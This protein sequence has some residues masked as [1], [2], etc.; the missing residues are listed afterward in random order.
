MSA[1]DTKDSQDPN[2]DPNRRAAV[3]RARAED[4]PAAAAVFA[5]TFDASV[6]AR[7]GAHSSEAYLR[8]WVSDPREFMVV[9]EDPELGIV[10]GLLGTMRKDD[11]R[12]P[13][14]RAAAPSFGPAFAH[15]LLARPT[16]AVEFGRRLVSGARDALA[17][18]VSP[19]PE[20]EVQVF[21]PQWP[22]AS[23]IGEHL[24]YVAAY[25][26]APEA[27]GQRLATRMCARAQEL[28]AE[29]GL[30]WC[31]VATYTDNI[32]SQTTAL[33]AGF[34][35]VKQVG[36][37][38]Q[39]R[40]FIGQGEPGDL[41]VELQ[42]SPLDDPDLPDRWRD[43]LERTPDG[44]GFHTWPWRRALLTDCPHAL[45]AT[46]FLGDVPVALF[47]L[48]FDPQAG[49]LGWWG[50]HRSNYSGP[51]YD[52]EHLPSVLAGLRSIAQELQPRAIDF[53]GLREHSPF[54]RAALDLVLGEHGR[55]HA[56]RMIA[57]SE[58]D[59][60]EGWDGV[61]RRRKRKHR[62]NW[63]RALRKLEELGRVEF[64]EHTSS[65]AIAAV[66]DDAIR[67]YE[68]R[69]AG[70]NVEQA[71]G[72]EREAFQRATASAL[73]DE[74]HAV[75]SVLSVQDEVIAFSYALRQGGVSNS[76]TLAHDDDYAPYSPGQLLLNDVLER[77]ARR[78]DPSFDFSVGDEVYKEVWST[79]RIGV[80][81][82]AWGAGAAARCAKDRLLAAAREQPTLRRLKQEGLRSLVPPAPPPLSDWA[83]HR[84]AA[85]DTGLRT[86]PLDL[87]GLRTHVPPELFA[88][89]IDRVF[90][91]DTTVLVARDDSPVAIVW[92][93]AEFRRDGLCRGPADTEVFFDLRLLEPVDPAAVASAL[94]SCLLVAAPIEG[95]EVERTFMAEVDL[96]P[97]R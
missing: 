92:K 12:T 33:R 2:Q 79:A 62:N 56:A 27:R 45:V 10:G 1:P 21:E 68:R 74:G 7:M 34:R 18:R 59:L 51:L 42:R 55:P 26:V 49:V 19:P 54:R 47:P 94:G 22:E 52:P 84:V 50:T 72:R 90:R 14:L 69:W 28:F 13:V 11:H 93:A 53:S 70:F 25:W 9:A 87:Q 4:L 71:F 60:R 20:P 5:R 82:L 58:I 65:G 76:Y 95:L 39:Y 8:A 3:R 81:R 15:D 30:L 38:L 43:L 6:W 83:V 64:E 73:A 96:T 48:D 85:A 35:L 86:E 80:Y 57:A 24:G 46:V 97:K 31:E 63:R 67:L 29:Q 44:S 32:A 66:M 37:H 88:L 41:R 36:E 91:G 23:E 77:A 89:A 78:G 40:M 61:W 75:M 16:T 17:R